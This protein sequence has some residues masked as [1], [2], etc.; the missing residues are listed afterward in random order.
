LRKR[1]RRGRCRGTARRLRCSNVRAN[2]SLLDSEI[3]ATHD[4]TELKTYL[5]LLEER[6]QAY[7]SGKSVNQLMDEVSI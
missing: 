7:R 1:R 4:A 6:F 5:G 3:F 2:L